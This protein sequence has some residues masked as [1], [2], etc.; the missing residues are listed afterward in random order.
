MSM[1]MCICTMHLV[2]YMCIISNQGI[3]MCIISNQGIHT[4]Y[5]RLERYLYRAANATL[6]DI[7]FVISEILLVIRKHYRVVG[8]DITQH[9]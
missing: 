3:H 1:D 8:D 6:I 9:Q 4:E 2:V 7:R 5:C